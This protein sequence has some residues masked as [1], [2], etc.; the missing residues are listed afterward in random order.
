[1]PSRV[2]TAMGTVAELKVA[3]RAGTDP[4]PAFDDAFAEL[5]RI[6]GWTSS[7]RDTS[8]VARLRASGSAPVSAVTDEILAMALDIATAG[9]GAFDPTT[10][11]LVRTWGYPDDPAVPD[12]GAVRDA[13]ATIG[14]D[15]VRRT[16]EQSWITEPGVELDLGGIAKGWAVDR[17]ADLLHERVG[18]C[19]VNL[20]GDLAVR[21]RKPDGSPWKVGVQDPRDPS[22]LFVTLTLSG[23]AAVATS[24]DY[25]R[26]VEVDGVRFHHLLDPATGWPARGVRSATVVAGSCAEADAWATAIFILGPERGLAALEARPGL[27]GVLVT[28]D[29]A[30]ELVRHESSG[31]AALEATVGG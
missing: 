1:M 23:R 15:R 26:Y 25:Q 12:S 11:A 22:R 13:L 3:P 27:E 19:L 9:D 29:E 21:G 7:Y 2:G 30:G 8:D 31:F 16:G 6:E 4:A 17:V 5:E 20:G 28:T 24:G 10:G 14:V 18:P